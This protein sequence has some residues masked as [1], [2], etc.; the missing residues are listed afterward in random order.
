MKDF[1]KVCK[2]SAI[3]LPIGPERMA[4]KVSVELHGHR[5]IYED[6][7]IECCGEVALLASQ[8]SAK[9]IADA[10]W[11]ESTR[12]ES[13]RDYQRMEMRLRQH[14]QMMAAAPPSLGASSGAALGGLGSMLGVPKEKTKE[15]KRGLFGWRKHNEEE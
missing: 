5:V 14:Q 1:C 15:K 10:V 6:K 4:S 8:W 12:R 11:N 2:L 13:E 7:V 9:A 3:C